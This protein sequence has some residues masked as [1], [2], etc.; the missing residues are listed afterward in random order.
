MSSCHN[1]VHVKLRLGKSI[2]EALAACRAN[3]AKYATANYIRR[4]R[5][6]PNARYFV[7]SSLWD[8]K[9]LQFPGVDIYARIGAMRDLGEVAI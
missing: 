6:T 4:L 5:T 9:T 3:G 1:L 7:N 8:C 2:A